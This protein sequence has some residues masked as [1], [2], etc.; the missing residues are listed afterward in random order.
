M[1]AKALAFA[2]ANLLD[3]KG[4]QELLFEHIFQQQAF[5]LIV[6]DFGFSEAYGCFIRHSVNTL[7]PIHQVEILLHT[8][9]HR[10]KTTGTPNLHLRRKAA[11]QPDIFDYFSCAPVLAQKLGATGGFQRRFLLY[12]LDQVNDA[13]K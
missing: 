2:A 12:F 10:I 6:T 5:S 1:G 3:R 13:G 7:G 11:H 8:A 4:Q 9:R